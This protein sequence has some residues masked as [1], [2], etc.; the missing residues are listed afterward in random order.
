MQKY[1]KDREY[2]KLFDS[3]SKKLQGNMNAQLAS[4]AA[5]QLT[6]IKSEQKRY[7]K[8]RGKDLFFQVKKINPITVQPYQI[9]SEKVNGDT[10]ILTVEEQGRKT[11]KTVS[12]VKEKGIWK[13]DAEVVQ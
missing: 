13:M 7:A 10:A 6:S 5:R 12:L 8:M 3:Y 11:L 9:L 4:A 2:G 1:E